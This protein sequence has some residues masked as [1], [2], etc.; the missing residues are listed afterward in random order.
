M[1]ELEIFDCE[2]GTPEWLAARAGII[3]ASVFNVVQMK[4]RGGG[5]S[6]TRRKLLYQLAAEQITGMPC[7]QWG[8]NEHTERGHAMENEI[9][10]LYEASSDAPVM[11]VGF[12]RRGRIGASPD[13]LVGDDG[14]VEIKSRLPHLQIDVLLAGVLPQEH[15]AQVQGQL[16]VSRRRWCDYV[17]Y[18]PG[19]PEFRI[20]VYPDLAYQSQLAADIRTFNAELDVLVARIGGMA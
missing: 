6:E 16:M 17:S 8:G 4:G 12:M 20:R 10:A 3:T 2:Q 11:Q 13:S 5:V 15:V 14:M 18:W 7:P 1:D 19:L 9:R